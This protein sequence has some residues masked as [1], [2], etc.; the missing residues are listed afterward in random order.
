MPVR[1]LLDSRSGRLVTFGFLYASQGIPLGFAAITMA[2]YMHRQGV[3]TAD[4]GAFVGAFFLPWAFK[5][6]WAPL[7]DLVR[8]ERFGGRKGWIVLCQALMIVTL[9]VVAFSAI[10]FAYRKPGK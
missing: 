3:D 1:N 7:V 5:W 9:L 2:A 8:L 10:G 4:I 6:A